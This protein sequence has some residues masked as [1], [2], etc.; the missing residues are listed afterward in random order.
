LGA[1]E[2]GLRGPEMGAEIPFGSF[3]AKEKSYAG[4]KCCGI[5]GRPADHKKCFLH[6]SA[7]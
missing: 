1:E 2:M 7:D 3:N 6:Q 4:L 5:P